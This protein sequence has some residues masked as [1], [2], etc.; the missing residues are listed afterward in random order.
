M[1]TEH[2]HRRDTLRAAAA[3][4]GAAAAGG[5]AVAQPLEQALGRDDTNRGSRAPVLFLGHGSP[6]NAIE[7]NRWSDAFQR[8][9]ESLPRPTAVLAVSA[10]W[11]TK[12][13]LVTTNES[14]RTIHDFGGF[15]AALFEVRYPAPGSPDLA[16]R[17][18]RL[19]AERA[20]DDRIVRTATDWGL[21]HGTW[22]VL[23]HLLPDADVPVVQLSLDAGLTPAQHLELA[24]GLSELR[25][26]GVLILGS[27]NVTHNLPDAMARAR[28]G[29]GPPPEW[30]TRFD[31]EAASA[32]EARDTKHLVARWPDGQDARRAHPHPD[33]WLP[34]LYAYAASDA[35]D[36]ATFPIEGFDLGSISMRAVRWG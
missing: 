35:A 7:E 18:R 26:D 16:R 21:D 19:L 24:R 4:A 8:I 11:W 9:G 29:G 10:H 5:A 15:P 33:H 14:P 12:G 3:L 2:P 1:S 30:A 25:D 36:G 28:D 22:S 6:M 17:V 27:G 20:R 13:T 23:R 34:L 32:I 31:A